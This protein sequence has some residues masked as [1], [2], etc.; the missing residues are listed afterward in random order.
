MIGIISAM[1]EEI[2]LML[3]QM[4]DI[5]ETVSANRTYYKGNIEEKEVV[6]AFSRWGKVASAITATDM[7]KSFSVSEIIFAGVAGAISDE[8]K[9]GDIVIGN[10][11]Y[12]HDM[13][14]TPIFNEYEIPLTGI[15]HYITNETN[16]KNLEVAAEHFIANFNIEKEKLAEFNITLPNVLSGIIA[17]GDQFVDTQEKRQELISKTPTLLCVEMEGASVAQVCQEFNVPYSILRIIS[18]KADHSAAVDFQQFVSKIAS[19]YS[20]KILTTYLKF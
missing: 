3:A 10:K 18:D 5:K 4:T 15:T 16:T 19:V 17:S 1:S 12:Q 20:L 6:I 7:I 2:D 14:A 9:I 13:N 8:L 11:L